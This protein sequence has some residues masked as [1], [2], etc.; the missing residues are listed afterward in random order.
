MA[1]MV[2]TGRR[3][4]LPVPTGTG[5]GY[6]SREYE[7]AVSFIYYLPDNRCGKVVIDDLAVLSDDVLTGICD[8][9]EQAAISAYESGKTV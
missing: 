4:R 3:S 6:V 8:G 2:H 5:K 7:G 9:I 1:S